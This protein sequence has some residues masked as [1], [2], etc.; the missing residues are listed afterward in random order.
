MIIF[1]CGLILL[2]SY[3]HINILFSDD[4]M[5]N[6]TKGVLVECDPAMKQFL[7]HLDE[8]LKLG[9]RFIIQDLDETHVFVSSDVVEQLKAHIDDFMDLDVEAAPEGS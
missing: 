9:S 6:V 3:I 2:K 7:L 1:I 8:T 5:V 4:K